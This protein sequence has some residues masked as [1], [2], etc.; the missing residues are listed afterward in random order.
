[1]DS[2]ASIVESNSVHMMRTEIL[3]KL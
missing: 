1:M 2:R 3:T